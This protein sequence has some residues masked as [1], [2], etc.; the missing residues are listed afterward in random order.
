M[1][2]GRCEQACLKTRRLQDGRDHGGAAAFALRASD[3]DRGRGVLWISEAREKNLH[4]SEVE[5][6]RLAH[7]CLTLEIGEHMNVWKKGLDGDRL[8]DEELDRFSV[9]AAAV[10]E[11]NQRVFI[12]WTRIGPFD[13]SIAASWFAFALYIYPGLRREFESSEQFNLSLE[14]AGGFNGYGAWNVAVSEYLATFDREKPA[15]PANKRYIF[16]AY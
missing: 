4:P 11:Y 1:Q 3:V 6:W 7:S 2:M 14:A 15:I 12:R 10:V 16:W 8:T 13:P 9:L 5:I